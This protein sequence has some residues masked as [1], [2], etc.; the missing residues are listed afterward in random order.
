MEAQGSGM[1]GEEVQGLPV[2]APPAALHS[3]SGKFLI[4]P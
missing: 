3:P 4:C 1:E 2:G